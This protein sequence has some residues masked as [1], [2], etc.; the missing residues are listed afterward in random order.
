MA[1]VIVVAIFMSYIGFSGVIDSQLKQ[2]ETIKDKV[3]ILTTDNS[4]FGVGFLLFLTFAIGGL[5]LANKIESIIDNK[6]KSVKN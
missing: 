2:L 5:F 4:N 6:I 3:E 1:D